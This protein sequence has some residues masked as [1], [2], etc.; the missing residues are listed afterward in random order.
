[1][2]FVS[3]SDPNNDR[4]EQQGKVKNIKVIALLL[5]KKYEYYKICKYLL[6]PLHDKNKIRQKGLKCF[7]NSFDICKI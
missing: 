3:W 4:I 1:V 2:A 7:S 6:T 5:K